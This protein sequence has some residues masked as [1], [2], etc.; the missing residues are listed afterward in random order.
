[1]PEDER[2]ILES[3][4]KWKPE[5]LRQLCSRKLLQSVRK[6]IAT[7]LEMDRQRGRGQA[8]SV[9]SSKQD[10]QKLQQYEIVIDLTPQPPPIEIHPVSVLMENLR[11]F[12]FFARNGVTLLQRD[13][14]R[15]GLQT[16]V[17]DLQQFEGSDMKVQFRGPFALLE[18]LSHYLKSAS[19]SASEF[20]EIVPGISWQTLRHQLTYAR[21]VELFRRLG[22]VGMTPFLS[23]NYHH[24]R[25]LSED[26]IECVIN[27]CRSQPKL[28]TLIGVFEESDELHRTTY[29]NSTQVHQLA[30]APPYARGLINLPPIRDVSKERPEHE[31]PAMPNMLDLAASYDRHWGWNP[32]MAEGVGML[33]LADCYDVS[34]SG[35]MN[36]GIW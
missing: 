16:V 22:G 28:S 34:V 29:R 25:A 12:Q 18:L 26:E 31:S 20:A 23:V 17:H 21:K 36:S 5:R 19:N 8:N 7:A 6:V 10:H 14:C 2:A 27:I 15:P 32:A 30:L 1:M 3:V 35:H 11:P 33:E 24:W 13:V 4:A 9:S